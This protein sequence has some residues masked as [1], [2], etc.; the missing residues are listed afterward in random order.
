MVSPTKKYFLYR[1]KNGVP[2]LLV[3][4]AVSLLVT[5]TTIGGELPMSMGIRPYYFTLVGVGIALYAAAVIFT[6]IELL[7]F[8]IRREGDLM[9]PLASAGKLFICRYGTA[10]FQSFCTLAVTFG[11]VFLR[12]KIDGGYSF[13]FFLPTVGAFA[14]WMFVISALTALGFLVAKGLFDALLLAVLWQFIGAL[15]AALGARLSLSE[16]NTCAFLPAA[17]LKTA[18][19][20]TGKIL[21][22]HREYPFVSDRMIY[23]TANG[24]LPSLILYAALAVCAL[25]FLYFFLNRY[26]ADRIGGRSDGPLAYPFLVPYTA[27]SLVVINEP[28][29]AIPGGLWLI[30]GF[31]IMRRG[32]RWKP[33]DLVVLSLTAGIS[34]FTYLLHILR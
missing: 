32:F 22:D 11:Y 28:Y 29:Y 9:L 8:Q 2:A 7:P 12:L 16:L 33:V 14:V 1:L 27:L 10:L 26:R 24:L 13:A 15:P 4:V 3:G 18:R 19:Y 31:V 20:C 21:R 30:A 17:V 5:Q 34:L 23:H 25:V 6:V